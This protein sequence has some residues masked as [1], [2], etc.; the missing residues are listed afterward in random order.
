M[1]RIWI[2]AFTMIALAA[3]FAAAQT[4]EPDPE[5]QQA[6][7]ETAVV[8][9]LGRVF[10]FIQTMEQ[11]DPSLELSGDQIRELY[12][13]MTAVKQ[14]DR[15]NPNRADEWLVTIEDQIL[16]V[17]QLMYVDQL[18]LARANSSGSGDGTGAGNGAGG[19]GTASGLIATYI[20]GGAF[21]PIIDASKSMGEDFLAYYDELT[22][23]R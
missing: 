12:T 21:N 10:G 11:E 4:T 17:D 2:L 9:D 6:K 8:F 5:V 22:A 3:G 23:R 14:S 16:T 1:K 13:I 20:A 18:Y 15:I 19:T 7:E